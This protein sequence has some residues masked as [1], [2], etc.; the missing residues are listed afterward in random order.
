MTQEIKTTLAELDDI[1][2]WL[3]G[4][5]GDFPDL[6]QKPHYAFR[7][8][9]RAK[10]E[11]TMPAIRAY[12]EKLE[13]EAEAGRVLVETM[14]SWHKDE[15]L[16][17]ECLDGCCGLE[18]HWEDWRDSALSAYHSATRDITSKNG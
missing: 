4:R 10:Y 3:F 6:S 7:T 15:Y 1:F 9:L 18:E 2:Q 12:I 11:A 5:G 14:Q 17:S 13:R 8:E 16:H